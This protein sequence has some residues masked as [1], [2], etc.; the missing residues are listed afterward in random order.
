[1]MILPVYVPPTCAGA[2]STVAPIQICSFPAAEVVAACRLPDGVNGVAE[3]CEL[4]VLYRAA[5]LRIGI[6][7]GPRVRLAGRVKLN[8]TAV[9]PAALIAKVP[10]VA[11]IGRMVLLT[12]AVT[13]PKSRSVP[14]TPIGESTVAVTG[15]VA[16]WAL[17]AEV[18]RTRPVI[19]PKTALKICTGG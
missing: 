17:S 1:M 11:A 16:P 18:P 10:A 3:G 19:T 7:L 6:E 15:V 2:G 13:M 8:C 5:Q 9:L 4:L 12:P 14:V